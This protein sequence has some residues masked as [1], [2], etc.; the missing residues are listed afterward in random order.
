MRVAIATKDD[1]KFKSA[2]VFD[3]A[4]LTDRNAVNSAGSKTRALL[5]FGSSSVIIP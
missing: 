4:E 3:P 5:N 2:L 1:P